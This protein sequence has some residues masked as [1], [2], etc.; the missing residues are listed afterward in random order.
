MYWILVFNCCK[1]STTNFVV[2][3]YTKFLSSDSKGQKTE[4]SLTGLKSRY[5]RAVFLL[6][7]RFWGKIYFLTFSSLCRQP[8]FLGLWPP[9]IF[10]ASNWISLNSASV[11]TYPISPAPFFHL[12]GPL[13]LYWVHL[14]NPGSSSYN[15]ILN[16]ICKVSCHVK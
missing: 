12:Q 14:D 11:I 9:F 7:A 1:Q 13:W 4:M 15:K 16:H 8:T 2:Q 6:E 5:Y 3:S 10:K